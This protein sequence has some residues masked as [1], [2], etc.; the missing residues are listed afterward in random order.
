VLQE[1]HNL[2]A[3][4]NCEKK[5]GLTFLFYRAALNIGPKTC[6]S[7]FRDNGAEIPTN[8]LRRPIFPERM[9]K[10]RS[11]SLPGPGFFRIYRVGLR[12]F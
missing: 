8:R 12:S 5:Y 10:S 1:C 9:R 6:G 7:Y 3:W 4:N 2:I 11:G